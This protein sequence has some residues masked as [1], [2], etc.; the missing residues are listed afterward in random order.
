MTM[1]KRSL[2]EETGT[3]APIP[4]RR[5]P[6]AIDASKICCCPLPAVARLVLP[7]ARH[8]AGGKKKA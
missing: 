1:L 7:A 8:H 2:A 3:A 5:S 4:K 6:P